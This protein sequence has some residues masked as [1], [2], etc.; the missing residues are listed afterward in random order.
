MTFNSLNQNNKENIKN[1]SNHN[2]NYSEQYY[3]K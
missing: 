3:I 1:S 2:F